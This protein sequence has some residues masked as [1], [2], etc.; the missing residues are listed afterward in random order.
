MASLI[1]PRCD[2]PLYLMENEY[3][4]KRCGKLE[5]YIFSFFL[6][7]I[8]IVISI[9]IYNRKLR[10]DILTEDEEK[11]RGNRR[12]YKYMGITT[13][14]VILIWLGSPLLTSWL[15][16]KRWEGYKEQIKSY[17]NQGFT[18]TDAIKKI[19]DMHQTKIQANAI[20]SGAANIAAALN[21][22]RRSNI[23]RSII[24]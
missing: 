14:I 17:K 7:I 12:L 16:V 15:K 11:K 2:V 23:N 9:L 24:S 18:N 5:G 20:T 21:A 6:S 4:V 22:S 19:Q 10:K 8:V 3:D 1:D 13:I